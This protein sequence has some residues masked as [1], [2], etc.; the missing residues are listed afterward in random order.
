MYIVLPSLSYNVSC[1]SKPSALI[2]SSHADIPYLAINSFSAFNCSSDK[3]PSKTIF[4]FSPVVESVIVAPLLLIDI[5][6]SLSSLSV[7]VVFAPLILTISFLLIDNTFPSSFACFKLS[8]T[9]NTFIVPSLV[10][11]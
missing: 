2:C 3:F 5:F 6:L 9:D 11:A 10:C 7:I 4:F 1:F 8:L